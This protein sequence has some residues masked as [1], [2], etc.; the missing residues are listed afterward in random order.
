MRYQADIKQVTANDVLDL[1]Q[2]IREADAKELMLAGE[3]SVRSAVERSVAKSVVC[4]AARDRATQ[5]LLC[6]CGVVP[7][8]MD[9]DTACM[10]ELSTQSA[11]CN[12]RTF[13]RNSKKVLD[14]LMEATPTIKT[15]FNAIPSEY[16]GYIQW[17]KR[18]LGAKFDKNEA[19]S[20][21]GHRFRT[22]T[23]T[24]GAC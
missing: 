17:A 12:R 21:T 24:K 19:I 1:I 22:W 5:E 2:N 23:I 4:L 15:Y 13:L 7:V 16:T 20:P 18:Y 3:K 11:Q 9:S 8:A 14:M 6:I 10:W